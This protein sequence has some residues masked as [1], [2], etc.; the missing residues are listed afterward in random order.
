MRKIIRD[1]AIVVDDWQHLEDSAGALPD[2]NI[3]V[4]FGR[5]QADRDALGARRSGGVGVR[6]GGDQPIDELVE[7]LSYLSL[8]AL[9]FPSF[10]D[11]RCLSHARVL[12]ERYDFSG[13]LRAVGDV[14]RDQ[15]FYMHRVGINAFEPRP[16]RRL[17]DALDALKDFS[18]A[19]Q[20]AADG[21]IPVW[22]RR[23]GL[24]A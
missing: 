18:V 8:V 22:R 6:I 12:R 24:A 16:D 23:R 11:G 1:G 9:E 7:D 17:E 4:S 21:A 15:M 3:I 5:W 14:L 13:E 19:Y 10:K 20:P 2:G